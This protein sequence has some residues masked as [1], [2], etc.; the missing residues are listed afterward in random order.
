MNDDESSDENNGSSEGTINAVSKL[1]KEIPIYQDA[2]QP[3][4]K[5]A[6]KALQTVGTAVN[7]ALL[8]IK[9]LVWGIEKIEEFVQTKVTEKLK[10]I[11]PENIQT[12]DPS[13]AGP[14]LESLRYTGHKESLSEMYA[15]LLA[16]SMDSQTAENAHPGF[17]EIIRNMSSDEAKIMSYL[18]N[19]DMYPVIDI[20]KVLND[21]GG[22]IKTHELISGIGHDAA[23]EHRNLT[24]SYLVNLERLGLI[25][26]PRTGYI[27]EEKGYERI[28]NDA[29]VKA[30][31]DQLNTSDEY[32]GNIVKHYIRLTPLGRLFGKACVVSKT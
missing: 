15:N 7:A 30:V 23:C 11:P 18:I 12:P 17:V 13:V 28:I 19:T 25:E 24:S 9:G 26:I 3:V 4:A 27:T 5:E 29:P 2:V 32:K 6:G 20:E 1:V 21:G 14:A 10:S 22:T 8:P 16:S 31:M